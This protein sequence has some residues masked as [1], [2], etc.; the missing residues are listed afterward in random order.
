MLPT[1]LALMLSITAFGGPEAP[2]ASPAI[3]APPNS[4]T[5]PPT[6]VDVESEPE[7]ESESEPEPESEAPSETDS[8]TE[9]TAPVDLRSVWSS[10]PADDVLAEARLRIDVRDFPAADERLAFLIDTTDAP[11]AWYERGRSLELQERYRDALR[12]YAAA[13]ERAEDPLLIRDLLYRQTIA[14]NDL[15]RHQEA[16]ALALR[17]RKLDTLEATARPVVE[18]ELG[19]AEASLKRR[20]GH[21]RITRALAA[22]EADGAEHGWARSRARFVLTRQ[23]LEEASEI[24]LPGSKRGAR[25]LVRRAEALK[26]AEQQ[27]IA[28][29]KTGEPEY[30]LAGIMV[31]GDAYLALHDDLIASPPPRGLTADQVDLYQKTL[32]ERAAVLREKAWRFYDEGVS[33]AIRVQWHG[34]ITER[35]KRRRDA[36]TIEAGR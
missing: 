11:I 8:E 23:S 17:L 24:P 5:V 13:M 25:N 29:A 4:P 21:R 27:V 19:V 28:I 20:R 30:A 18:L 33:F 35:M 15:R 14:N 34:E 31:L 32:I 7:P 12:M 36:L 10:Q 22:L 16:R 26:A 1:L 9:P 3:E 2:E 6:E